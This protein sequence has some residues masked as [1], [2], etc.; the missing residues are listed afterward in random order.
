MSVASAA[1]AKTDSR[2][3]SILR[4][5]YALFAE[6]GYRDTNIADIA[7]SLGMGHG[8]FYRYFKNKRDIFVELV[9]QAGARIAQTVTDESPTAS[10][11]LEEYRAQ[12]ERWGRRIHELSRDDPALARLLLREAVSL[13][14]ELSDLVAQGWELCTSIT[15]QYIEHGQAKGYLRAD[16]PSRLVSVLLNAWIFE[17]LRRGVG[18]GPEGSLEKWLGCVDRVLFEGIAAR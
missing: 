16:V 10:Q 17:A 8:T 11:T 4:A 9:G 6:R 12:V 5:A 15:Q 14:P 18:H 2:R 1:K 7:Q 13:D 3:E